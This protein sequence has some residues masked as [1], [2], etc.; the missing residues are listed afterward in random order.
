MGFIDFSLP[1][2]V[3]TG[4][5]I[6]V[7]SLATYFR[8]S[9]SV[10]GDAAS[11][12]G[13][14]EGG[15][16]QLPPGPHEWPLV[17][18][19][20]RL[21]FS[22]KDQADVISDWSRRFGD[23]FT[24]TVLGTRF[25]ILSKLELIQKTFVNADINDMAPIPP[26]NKALSIPPNAG[27]G[28]IAASEG[29]GWKA[30]RR[31][32]MTCLRRTKLGSRSFEIVAA[33]EAERLLANFRS[34]GEDFFDPLP[35]VNVAVANV[36]TQL[37]MGQTY[38]FDDEE[39][40]HL[41]RLADDV[42]AYFGTGSILSAVPALSY[43]PSEETRNGEIAIEQMF[44]FIRKSAERH[45]AD[46]NAEREPRDLIECFLLE[47]HERKLKGDLGVFDDNNLLQFTWDVIIGGWQ[48]INTTILWY[49]LIL[50]YHPDVQ[51]RV[52]A[53]IDRVVGRHRRPS[54]AD[55][56]RL[57]FVE[58]AMAEC[59]RHSRLL[60]VQ[61]P[62]RTRRDVTVAGYHVPAGT[63]VASN[64]HFLCSSPELWDKPDEF[65]PERFLDETGAFDRQREAGMVEFGV[66]RRACPGEQLSRMELFIMFTFI[67]QN[68]IIQLPEGA[69]H[70]MQGKSG[71]TVNPLPFKIRASRRD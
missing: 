51:L 49:L 11:S 22:G 62:H 50:A 8:A 43:F 65:Y 29:P 14:R 34:F 26:C 23:V 5:V 55:R 48:T 15:R 16:R 27:I 64:T 32:L 7:H 66:G 17:G 31:F 30:L 13:P 21:L 28:I 10:S 53:E 67:F 69:P 24:F 60:P 63:Y 47:Q 2:A 42:F 39:F 71:L 35:S 20:P 56:P 52:Q 57:P 36:M 45:R 61:I 54:L 18:S 58:A 44:E 59:Y 33:D 9:K 46:F 19:L 4:C 68:F 70:T 37:A 12:R 6:V 38:D 41:T 1:L 3:V 25:V 40:Q